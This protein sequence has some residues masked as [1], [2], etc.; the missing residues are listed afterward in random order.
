M[1]KFSDIKPDTIYTII[2]DIRNTIITRQTITIVNDISNEDYDRYVDLILIFFDT[3]EREIKNAY[4]QIWYYSVNEKSGVYDTS[5]VINYLK[6]YKE[7]TI[8][9][10]RI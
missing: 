8:Y 2:T 1:L 4:R 5:L 6:E 7:V 3:L 9:C 10:K